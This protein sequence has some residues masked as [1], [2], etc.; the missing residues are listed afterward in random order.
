M[1]SI[2]VPREGDDA[3]SWKS[4][5]VKRY[6]YPRPPRGGRR[7]VTPH[8]GGFWRISIHVPREG[9]DAGVALFYFRPR[10]SIHVPREGD[11]LR[12]LGK[13]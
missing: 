2:H 4:S 9:D 3:A 5:A 8:I 11:D 6:F 12:C 7:A 10:I 1:I 13:L